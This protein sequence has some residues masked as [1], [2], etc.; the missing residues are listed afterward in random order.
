MKVEWD[1]NHVDNMAMMKTSTLCTHIIYIYRYT[2][3]YMG[4]YEKKK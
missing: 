3:I 4:A 1:T 2:Y